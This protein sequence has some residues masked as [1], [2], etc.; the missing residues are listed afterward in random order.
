[1]DYAI[2]KID[3]GEIINTVLWDGV[4]DWTLPVG[5]NVVGLQT[6]FTVGDLYVD[7]QFV[8]VGIATT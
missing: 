1:M 7:G 8:K 6:G 2:Y 3:D 5:T 4:S